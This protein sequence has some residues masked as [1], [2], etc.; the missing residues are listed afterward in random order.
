MLNGEKEVLIDRQ[1]E[2]AGPLLAGLA[3]LVFTTERNRGEG[4]E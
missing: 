2:M 4:Q 1:H 3:P